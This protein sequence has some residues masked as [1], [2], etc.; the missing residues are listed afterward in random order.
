MRV[1]QVKLIKMVSC[2]KVE[3]YLDGLDLGHATTKVYSTEI[4]CDSGKGYDFIQANDDLR[5]V[6]YD[7]I[8]LT[9]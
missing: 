2:D 8:D 3:I 7:F 6:G 4:I 1:T 5:C 9:I